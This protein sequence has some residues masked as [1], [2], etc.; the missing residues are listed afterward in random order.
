MTPS[1]D[2]SPKTLEKPK[3][4]ADEMLG[5]LAKWLRLLGYD[6]KY[7]SGI[8]DSKVLELAE[9]EGRMILTRDTSLIRRRRCRNYIFVRDDH[10]RR[11]LRQVYAEAKLNLDS[12]LTMC[13]VCNRPL[14]PVDKHSVRALAPQYVYATRE[15]FSRCANC[16]RIF[17]AATHTES[18][19]AELADLAE[20]P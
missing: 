8:P 10:W 17:W 15:K 2:S 12:A 18:I 3:F 4:L 13:A 9:S 16:S 1:P 7:V 14:R 11:Q 20:E 5:R 6:T 19:L